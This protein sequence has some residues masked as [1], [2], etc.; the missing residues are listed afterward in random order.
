MKVKSHVQLEFRMLQTAFQK[1]SQKDKKKRREIAENPIF[2]KD[3]FCGM[4]ISLTSHSKSR[5]KLQKWF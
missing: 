1:E 3:G 2:N 4:F 5:N